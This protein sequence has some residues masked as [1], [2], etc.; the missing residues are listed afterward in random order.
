MLE[1]LINE[2]PEDLRGG[3][4]KVFI[5]DMAMDAE[6]FDD[7]LHMLTPVEYELR[8]ATTA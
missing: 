8:H 2:N 4:A 6:G 1:R 3:A 5:F 7:V